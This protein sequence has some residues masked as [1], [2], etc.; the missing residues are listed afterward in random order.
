MA[1]RDS[2]RSSAP[3][4]SAPSTRRRFPSST[5]TRGPCRRQAMS[6]TKR[7]A[8]A[9][10]DSGRRQTAAQ[11]TA[12]PPP[13]SRAFSPDTMTSEMRRAALCD[14]A[15]GTACRGA[16]AG[17]AGFR[18]TRRTGD[19]RDRSLAHRVHPLAKRKCAQNCEDPES[20]RKDIRY[21]KS[22][23]PDGNK[24]D[25]QPFSPLGDT[26]VTTQAQ[27]LSA[28]LG[29]GHQSADHQ[30]EWRHR[31]Q[32][33]LMAAGHEP[34][35]DAAEDGGIA[36]PIQGGIQESA[37]RA[38]AA[39]HPVKRLV[40]RR[41]QAGQTRSQHLEHVRLI[42]PAAGQSDSPTVQPR[43]QTKTAQPIATG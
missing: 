32:H 35:R 23:E 29:V 25:N 31:G 39:L 12:Y 22:R 8:P 15:A 28:R 37:K 20:S 16:G 2:A 41:E 33:P 43:S 7:N 38:A 19:L 34:D 24:A 26:D 17:S 9:A 4:A 21:A 30:A 5:R 36:D 42:L 18:A 6:A 13:T 27:A 3:V 11:A 40:H 14:R 10:H 1:A